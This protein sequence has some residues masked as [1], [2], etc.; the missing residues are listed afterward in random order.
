MIIKDNF[1][2]YRTEVVTPY[3]EGVQDGIYHLFVLNSDN[4]MT[5]SSNQFTTD[6]IIKILLIYI[7]N[8]IVIM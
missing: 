1:F 5:D 2:V 7:Q 3:I 6:N 8:M 4:A